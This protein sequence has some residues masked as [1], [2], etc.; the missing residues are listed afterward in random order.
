[1][2]KI[3]LC[4]PAELLLAAGFGCEE[5]RKWS[6]EQRKELREMLRDYRWLEGQCAGDLFDWKIA[7]V[8]IIEMNRQHTTSFTRERAAFEAARSR[9]LAVTPW[10]RGT[11]ATPPRGWRAA[12]W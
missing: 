8:E 12:A 1:M 10:I 2:K 5:Q 7:E 3:L 9:F 11:P 4:L 6:R